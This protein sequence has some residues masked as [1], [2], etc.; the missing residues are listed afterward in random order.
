[1]FR[2]RLLRGFSAL[3]AVV[4]A[5]EASGLGEK[6][7]AA[8]EGSADVMPGEAPLVSVVPVQFPVPGPGGEF[9]ESGF[10]LRA[11]GPGGVVAAR[12]DE[13]ARVDRFAEL[14]AD[15]PQAF[16]GFLG[17]ALPAGRAREGGL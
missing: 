13:L 6:V 16:Q 14:V 4:I 2:G 17:F 3:R 1:M 7:R 5:R 9:A 11:P 8:G 10:R 12:V 15:V